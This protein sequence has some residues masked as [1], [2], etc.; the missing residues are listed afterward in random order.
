MIEYLQECLKIYSEYENYEPTFS[1]VMDIL[2]K[3]YL[4]RL[5]LVKLL[6]VEDEKLIRFM[7]QKAKRLT[8]ANFG[9]VILLY[10]PLYIANYCEN[11]C[12]YC[13]FS[14][15]KKYP[16]EKLTFQEMQNEM[17]K[18]KD[19]G[20]DSIII[21]TGEDRT[22]SSFEYIKEACNLALK[23]F[24]EVSIEVYPL[25]EKEYEELSRLGVVGIT[26][27]QETYQKEDYEK[28]HLF[29]PKKDYEFRLYTPERAL[30]AGFH[31]ACV[32][33]LLGLSN[34]KKDAYCAIL[35][36]E[37]LMNRFPKAEISI[38]FPRFR[39]ANVGFKPS[40]IVS[41]KEYIKFLLVSRIYLPR[42]GIVISTRERA[43]LRDALMDI[44]ITKMSAGS[45]TTVGGYA[46]KKED[47]HGQ[48]EIDDARSVFEMVNT[49]AKKGL[50]AEFTNWVKGVGYELI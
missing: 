10:A 41:D 22:N 5:D 19:E 43:A 9:K 30:N 17:K 28:L 39:D 42:V 4:D 34:P 44:C 45:K 21:L 2:S 27:Y 33:P 8:E 14:C 35:H 50:R 16:R 11:G 36:A 31:E 6:N 32:G 15:L 48:F 38:S 12:L 29:G 13:G 24:S 37:Y 26:I 23:Y 49:I 46:V 20:L 18:M 3:E 1:E 40:Y 7:A 47:E 25:L